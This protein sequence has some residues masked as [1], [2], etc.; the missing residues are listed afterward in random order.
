MKIAFIVAKDILFG[1][2]VA[3]FLLFSSSA[4]NS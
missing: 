2:I 3:A 1:A 4:F